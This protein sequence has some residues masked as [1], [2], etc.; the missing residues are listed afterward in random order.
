MLK[1]RVTVIRFADL[2]DLPG[3]YGE[4]EQMQRDH[5]VIKVLQVV[6]SEVTVASTTVDNGYKEKYVHKIW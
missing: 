4:Q 6:T 2:K 1:R 5:L 3:C